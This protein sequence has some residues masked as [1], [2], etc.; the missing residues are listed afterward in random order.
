[1]NF[2]NKST[3]FTL[4]WIGPNWSGLFRW[5]LLL[6]LLL[7]LLVQFLVALSF[8]DDC[9]VLH[10]IECVICWL[11]SIHMRPKMICWVLY[12][13]QNHFKPQAFR[14]SSNFYICSTHVNV[15]FDVSLVWTISNWIWM[16]H[17]IWIDHKSFHI[18]FS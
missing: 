7:F 14:I 4:Y 11:T 16:Q 17:I 10:G 8:G 2:H 3:T 15:K 1:M 9:I 6:S 12:D 5:W 13:K 18:S